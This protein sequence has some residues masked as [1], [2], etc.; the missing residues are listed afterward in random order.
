MSGDAAD[1]ES[2]Y[3]KR[4]RAE[5]MI[6]LKALLRDY[7]PTKPILAAVEGVAIAGGTEIL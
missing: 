2:E 5:P 3:S 6:Q 4:V 7:R 1:T